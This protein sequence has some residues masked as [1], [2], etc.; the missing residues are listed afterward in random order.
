VGCSLFKTTNRANLKITD[1]GF[2]N[3]P[4]REFEY[5]V[6]STCIAEGCCHTAFTVSKNLTKKMGIPAKLQVLDDWSVLGHGDFSAL[7]MNIRQHLM[8]DHGC[9]QSTMLSE[10]PMLTNYTRKSKPFPKNK[11]KDGYFKKKHRKRKSYD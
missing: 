11:K 8:M 2:I 9:K 5:K 3:M 6:N 1:V 7:R 4:G 10:Y